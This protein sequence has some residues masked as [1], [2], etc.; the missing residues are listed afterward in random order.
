MSKS[1]FNNYIN[2]LKKMIDN[3]LMYDIQN[4]PIF[5]SSKYLI[6]N[7]PIKLSLIPISINGL[8]AYSTKKEKNINIIQKYTFVRNGFTEFMVIDSV[9]NHYN[10]NNSFWFFKFNSLEDWHKIVPINDS[11]NDSNSNIKI[12]YYGYRFPFFGLFPNIINV[13]NEEKCNKKKFFSFNLFNNYFPKIQA[14]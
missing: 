3:R 9:G 13:N 12:T 10:V 4:L 1:F 7:F 2:F 11:N 14:F 5:N 8:Y 6:S